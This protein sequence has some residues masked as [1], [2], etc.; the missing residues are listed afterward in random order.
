MYIMAVSAHSVMAASVTIT[1]VDQGNGGVKVTATGSFD[2][3]TTCDANGNNCTSNSTGCVEIPGLCSTCEKNSATCTRTID[4]AQLHGTHSWS[5]TAGDCKGSASDS[6]TLTLDNTPTINV[7]SPT[8]TVTGPFDLAGTATFKP[9]LSSYKG[10]I[11]VYLNDGLYTYK[12][13]YTESCTYSYKEL[14][15]KFFEMGHGGPYT[16]KL[17][18][19]GGGASAS[20]QSTFHVDNTPT[21]SV[22]SPTGTVSGPFDLAGT[23]TFKP[24]QNSYKGTIEVYLNGGLYTYKECYTQSCTYSYKE[25]SGKFFEMP[26]GGPYTLKLRASGGGASASDT[27]TFYVSGPV[28]NTGPTCNDTK[29]G[30]TVNLKSGNLYHDQ[31]VLK[32]GNQTF[33][34]GYNS[35]DTDTT[36]LGKG[37]THS[38]NFTVATA[39]YGLKLKTST[40][41]IIPFSPSGSNYLPAPQ[42]GDTSVLVKN[43][44]NSYTR[45]LKSGDVQNFNSAGKLISIADPRGNTTTLAYDTGSNLATVTGANGRVLTFTSSSGKITEIK[46]PAG[47]THT[48]TYSGNFL[49]KVT[50][51]LGNSWI[52][53]NDGYRLN[54]KTDPNGN[55]ISYTYDTS[56]KVIKSTDPEGKE[57]SISYTGATTSTFTEKDGGVWTQQYDTNLNLPISKTAPNGNIT[58]Y[59]YDNNGNTLSVTKPGGAVTRYTYDSAGNMTSITDPLGKTT[60]YTYN[61]L[62]QVLTATDANNHTTTNSY[63]TNGNLLQ[64]IDPAGAKTVFTYDAKG[65]LLTRTDPSNFTTTLTYD[66]ANNLITTKDASGAITSFTYDAN[67]NILTAKDPAGTITTYVYDALNRPVTITGPLGDITR[68]TY[69]KNG[70]RVTVT[71]GNGMVTTTTH[72]FNNQPLT[73]KDALGNI[74]TMVYSG[75]A[76]GSCGSSGNDKLISVTDANNNIT[77]YEYDQNG[78]L[79]KEIDP[80][81]VITNYSYDS[82]G[83]LATRTDGNGKTTTHAY[84]AADRLLSRTYQ[85]GSSDTFTYDAAGNL[86]TASNANIS[87]TLTRDADNRITA[88]TDSRGYGITYQYD[89]AGNRTEMKLQPGTTDQRVITYAYEYGNRLATLGTPAGN[90]SFVYDLLN[91]RTGLAYPNGVAT[92]YAYDD[93]GRLTGLA[94]TPGTSFSYTYDAVGNRTAKNGEGYLYDAVYRL[95]RAVTPAGTENFTY[96]AAGN[97]LTGPGSKDIGYLYNAGNRMTAG[98][99]LTYDYD[100]NGNQTNRIV[101]GATD[102]IWAQTWDYEN[103]LTKV[104]KIKGSERRTVSFKYDPFGRRIEKKLET[105]TEGVA[106]AVTTTYVYDNEDIVLEIQSDGATATTTRYIHGPGIDEPLALERG[107]SFHYFQADG[108]GSIV[109]ITGPSGNAVQSYTYDSFGMVTPST[110]FRNS[111]AFTG[112]EWDRETGLYYYR[113]RY[114]DPMEGRFI[115]KDPI[116]FAG[117]DVNLYGYAQNNPVNWVDPS[118]LSSA[119]AIPV[120]R[121]K[122]IQ[123]PG[124][125]S[126]AAARLVGIIGLAGTIGGS[127]PECGDNGGPPG[128]RDNDPCKG[129]RN[130]LIAH[131]RKLFEYM[132]NPFAH[133]NKGFLGNDAVRN[134]KIIDGRINSLKKQ[135]EN[136][137]KQLEECEKINGR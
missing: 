37:W 52:Y 44:D 12:S 46:D 28:H 91:R 82:S 64:T 129:L 118:G 68:Y 49:T 69:D 65:N 97:R 125:C 86:L 81:G 11:E 102:K 16:L 88:I 99:K 117:G 22:T 132:S 121:P 124:W 13:C 6:A 38:Y 21:I 9:T 14:S 75:G 137:R 98:R 78:K 57:K 53:E 106:K 113:A 54:K 5:A 31:P 20:A 120:P 67:G 41:E 62:G 23:A 115:S 27:S 43:S 35:L 112:R 135:I 30:S 24:T 90:F 123:I 127:V 55:V 19:S 126:F 94:H 59:T 56:G 136:F 96:D 73:I 63:D 60:T 74:T 109:T 89:P 83:R 51:P 119:I 61:N 18:A 79:A 50:D 71:D 10:T 7:A 32:F 39:I 100:N 17:K 42:S 92:T 85:D 84:D 107:G 48:F 15:G 116:S 110:E 70:N 103:R 8:G 40:G 104:E 105:V 1:A 66:A 36:P 101:P 87:Y 108:L 26:Q 114:Y 2:T 3:C 131:E 25:L 80:G 34:I 95:I 133:D 47:N 29:L 93:G 58:S 111:Y 76:C 4:R 77:R 72:N 33:E 134:Q 45:T 130:Q 122:D 128:C